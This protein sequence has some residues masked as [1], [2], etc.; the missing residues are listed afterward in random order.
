MAGHSPLD[1]VLR[2][3]R[4]ARTQATVGERDRASVAG[5]S[6]AWL[7]EDR[8]PAALAGPPRRQEARAARPPRGGPASA[9]AEGENSP[10]GPVYEP[11]N[12]GDAS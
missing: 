7:Q 5:T 8:G 2:T 6:D 12:E 10:S 9:C 3:P 4:D 11:A 1:A